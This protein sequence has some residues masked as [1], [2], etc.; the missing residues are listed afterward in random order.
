MRSD[1]DLLTLTALHDRTEREQAKIA[2]EELTAKNKA[3]ARLKK[4]EEML[5]KQKAKYIEM[6][7][8]EV[9]AAHKAAEEKKA[10]LEAKKG[11]DILKAQQTAAKIR[12]TGIFPK[13]FGC[14]AA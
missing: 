13:K 10:Q 3:E 4:N 2:A 5:E 14:F 11:Q 12:T 9:A 1:S 7:K 8:N 6:M